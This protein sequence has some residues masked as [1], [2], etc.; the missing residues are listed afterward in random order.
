MTSSARTL[1][2]LG[3]IGRL[4]RMAAEH[5]GRVFLAWALIALGLGILAPRVETALS[6]AGWQAS[7]SESVAGPRAGRPQLRRRG[8]L[9]A[10]GRRPLART[11]RRQL[12]ASAR[13]SRA[14]RTSAAAPTPP[15]ARSSRRSRASR[16]R[17]T[18]TPP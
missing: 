9:R 10:P 14:R 7:G 1:S 6:G 5:R 18:A 12:P 3:P 8:R 17:P 13:R 4:G 11:R 16:S 15:S 2:E